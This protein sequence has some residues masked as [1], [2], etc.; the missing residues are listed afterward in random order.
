MTI[1]ERLEE[2]RK[3]KGYSL[4]EAAEATKIRTE[5]LENMESNRFDADLPDIFMRGFLRNYALFLR[6]DATPL[7]TDYDAMRLGN[8]AAKK[9]PRAKPEP[10]AEEDAPSA[11]PRPASHPVVNRPP[12]SRPQEAPRKSFGR[13]VVPTTEPPEAEEAP[14]ADAPPAAK[15]EERPPRKKSAPAD[16]PHGLPNPWWTSPAAR[17]TGLVAGGAAILAA[18][19]FLGYA[20]TQWIEG[21]AE[22]VPAPTA[23]TEEQP[24][25]AI[26][27]PGDTPLVAMEAFALAASDTVHV[28]VTQKLDGTVLFDDTLAQGDRIELEKYGPVRLR[29]SRGDA[30]VIETPQGQAL[31]PQYAGAGVSTLP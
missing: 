11:E 12:A 24:D 10:E 15:R 8:R 14:P 20:V 5:Y 6:L 7:L 26:G 1:G 31:R 3:R 4:R 30:L 16:P 25:P 22:A 29:Y 27:D 28:Q 2:A 17:M 21:S 18:L 9:S 23:R 19:V 13:M